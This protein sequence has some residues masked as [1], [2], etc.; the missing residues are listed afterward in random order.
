MYNCKSILSKANR[1]IISGAIL[2][3]KTLLRQ[4]HFLSLLS[5]TCKYFCSETNEEKENESAFVQQY[6]VRRQSSLELLPAANREA[7]L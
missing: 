2:K 6:F 5:R 4:I 1:A 7:A 3:T